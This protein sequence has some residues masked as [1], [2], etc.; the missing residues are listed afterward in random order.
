M[1]PAIN[2]G[3]ATPGL[4]GEFL[5]QQYSP[6]SIQITY[7]LIISLMAFALFSVVRNA[8]AKAK[9]SLML[10]LIAFVFLVTVLSVDLYNTSRLDLHPSI[11][12][13]SVIMGTWYRDRDILYLYESHDYK[14]VTSEGAKIGKWNLTETDRGWRVNGLNMY[15][16]QA[17]HEYRLINAMPGD[18]DYWHGDLGLRRRPPALDNISK[19]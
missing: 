7:L 5:I 4:V 19:D 6:F 8:R 16:V 10:N 1:N 13:P 14:Y 3:A 12:S 11:P 9:T 2:M 15:V 18:W 17:R